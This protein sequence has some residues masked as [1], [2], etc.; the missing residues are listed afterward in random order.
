MVIFGLD[1]IAII[2]CFWISENRVSVFNSFS[3]DSTVFTVEFTVEF[4]TSVESLAIRWI[5]DLSG[6]DTTAIVRSLSIVGRAP[7]SDSQLTSL[8]MPYPAFS[9]IPTKRN[10][11]AIVGLRSFE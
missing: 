10:N 6:N 8:F 4:I 2:I 9:A 5:A 3:T 7:V 11:L 1:K